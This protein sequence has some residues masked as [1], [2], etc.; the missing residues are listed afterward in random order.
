[1]VFRLEL[2]NLN[3]DVLP[4]M[5]TGEPG[6]RN[7]LHIHSYV[8]AV[9]RECMEGETVP[10]HESSYLRTYLSRRNRISHS[11][12][13][14][15]SSRQAEDGSQYNQTALLTDGKFNPT[16]YAELGVSNIKNVPQNYTDSNGTCSL[17]TSQLP[18]H[19][20]LSPGTYLWVLS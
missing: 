9:L 7:H 13:V 18:M 11:H 8:G 10:I 20:I 19:C 16:S 2:H 5:V 12:P 14:L 3:G 1:M 17:P 15:N 6:Y 4:D